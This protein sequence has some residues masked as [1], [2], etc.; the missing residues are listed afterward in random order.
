[1]TGMEPAL[2]MA[3]GTVGGSVLASQLT[4]TSAP[5]VKPPPVMPTPDDAAVRSAQRRSI[6][7][8][9]ARRGRQST[10]LTDPLGGGDSKLGG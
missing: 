6:A 4:K 2:L 3:M 1:M 7:A 10:I 8:Q 5:E 9:L